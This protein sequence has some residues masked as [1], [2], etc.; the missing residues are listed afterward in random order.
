FPYGTGVAKCR[1]RAEQNRLKYASLLEWR[2]DVP[3]WVDGAIKKAAHPNPERRYEAI[4]ELLHDL[5]HPNRAFQSDRP[6]P[7][8]ERNP[9]VFWKLLSL[10]L[11]ALVV[12]LLATHPITGT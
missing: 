4:S 9:L 3:A 1:S 12:V 6:P 7:L 11:F 10:I 2:R 5:R 8:I